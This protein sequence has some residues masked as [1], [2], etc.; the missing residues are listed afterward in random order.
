M[1][2]WITE[3][4]DHEFSIFR[5]RFKNQFYQIKIHVLCLRITSTVHN[6]QK[7]LL[8]LDRT[9]EAFRSTWSSSVR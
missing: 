2:G 7:Y 6:I 3:S 1:S 9:L 8:C 5:G 4:R